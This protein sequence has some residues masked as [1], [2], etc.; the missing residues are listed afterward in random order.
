[1]VII[2]GTPQFTNCP[3]SVCFSQ[4]V[5]YECSVD[6]SD[7]ASAL[8][9]RVLDTNNDPITGAVT[10]NKDQS[11][12]SMFI[13]SKDFTANLTASS[14]PIV[15][16][17]TFTPSASI[18]NYTVECSATGPSGYTPVPPVTCTILIAGTINA[19]K[20]TTLFYRLYCIF[21]SLPFSLS[22]SKVFHLLLFPILL[23]SLP[24]LLNTPGYQ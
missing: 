21:S 10:Y 6:T 11:I 4:S 24:L 8:N 17:V 12:P 2:I 7:G 23:S 5:S 15:S 3:S 18:S 20:F 13:I 1:M 14:G 16:D 22:P 9:W 19:S